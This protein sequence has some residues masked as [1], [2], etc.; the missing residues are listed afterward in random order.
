MTNFARMIS[1]ARKRLRMNQADF[2]AMLSVSQGSISKWESGKESPRAETVEKLR[3]MPELT[4][5]FQRII[6]E[7]EAP[8]IG[9][10][11]IIVD[12]PLMGRFDDGSNFEPFNIEDVKKI[13]IPI[14]KTGE[15]TEY[16]A[17]IVSGTYDDLPREFVG[18]FELVSPGTIFNFLEAA[19]SCKVL[20]RTITANDFHVYWLSTPY[21]VTEGRRGGRE[22]VDVALWPHEVRF[23][24]YQK[25][26]PIDKS[27]DAFGWSVSIIGILRYVIYAP[28]DRRGVGGFAI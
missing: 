10:P 17:W 25:P 22:H 18:V 19:R 23:R 7:P 5:L 28:T 8:I 14:P 6:P 16:E 15:N 2:A 1:S 20:T 4:D 12:V 26:V 11:S 9:I 24:N 3:S 13:A 21:G 27:G